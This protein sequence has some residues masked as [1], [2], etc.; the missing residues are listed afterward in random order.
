MDLTSFGMTSV[1]SIVAICYFCGYCVKQT[2]IDN[3]YIPIIVGVI[4]G[5]LGIVGMKVIPDYPATD[6]ITA[7]AI[8]ITSGLSSTGI[9]QIKKQYLKSLEDTE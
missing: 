7:V 3:K 9:N 2:K 5:I 8:G 1:A 6:N 4:G